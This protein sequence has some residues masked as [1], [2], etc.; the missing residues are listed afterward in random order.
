MRNHYVQS[1]HRNCADS[2]VYDDHQD[3]YFGIVWPYL[4]IMHTSFGSFPI[5][6]I[7]AWSDTYKRTAVLQIR[8]L[9]ATLSAEDPAADL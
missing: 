6:F 9:C 7:H 3:G 8:Q 4:L 2:K 1:L 5:D